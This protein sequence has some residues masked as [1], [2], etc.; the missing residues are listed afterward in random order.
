[1]NTLTTTDVLTAVR[2]ELAVAAAEIEHS[3]SGWH[4]PRDDVEI[5]SHLIASAAWSKNAATVRR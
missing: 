2:E 1:M 5:G 4:Q 3:R